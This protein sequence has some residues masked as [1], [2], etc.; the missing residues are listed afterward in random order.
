[1]QV[2]TLSSHHQLQTCTDPRGPNQS[3]EAA[4]TAA[5]DDLIELKLAQTHVALT[6]GTAA[7]DDL[8]NLISR[9]MISKKT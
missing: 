5:D 7:D 8:L 6:A 4:S 9:Y 2:S 1:M 3:E